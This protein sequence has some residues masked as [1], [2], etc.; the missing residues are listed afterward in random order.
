MNHFNAWNGWDTREYHALVDLT[1]STGD[2]LKVSQ[3]ALY[4][5]VI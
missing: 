3:I 4:P 1:L 5:S 2:E